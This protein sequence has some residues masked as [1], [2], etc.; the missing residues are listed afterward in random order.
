MEIE[1]TFTVRPTNF[2][3]LSLFFL[4]ST[5]FFIAL[6]AYVLITYVAIEDH[7]TLSSRIV[8]VLSFSGFLLFLGGVFTT[9]LSIK[10]NELKDYQYWTSIIGFIILMISIAVLIFS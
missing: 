9:I 8:T 5:L 3:K 1:K 7:S 2:K 6:I 4:I 10:N